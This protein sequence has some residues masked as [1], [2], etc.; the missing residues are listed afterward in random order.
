MSCSVPHA[1][2]L[3]FGDFTVLRHFTFSHENDVS[4][5]DA[6]VRIKI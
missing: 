4:K 2:M 5:D 6:K 1:L 3:N